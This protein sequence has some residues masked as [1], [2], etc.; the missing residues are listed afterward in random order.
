MLPLEVMGVSVSEGERKNGGGH[1]CFSRILVSFSDGSWY[2]VI[3]N[4]K[5]DLQ[6]GDT[7][8]FDIGV[9]MGHLA[10]IYTGQRA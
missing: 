7:A 4:G 6:K 1:F 9:R 8:L 3:Q 10:L 5:V 2:E